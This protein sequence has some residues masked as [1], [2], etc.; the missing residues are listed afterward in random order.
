MFLYEGGAAAAEPVYVSD[1]WEAPKVQV[2]DPPVQLAAG[3]GITFRCTYQNDTPGE[4]RWG[5][6]GGEMCMPFVL[7]AYPEGSARGVPPTLS[8][9]MNDSAP[10]VLEVGTGGFGG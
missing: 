10:V 7:Y 1:D 8:A 5:V 3:D 2:L 6:V 9:L 4:L